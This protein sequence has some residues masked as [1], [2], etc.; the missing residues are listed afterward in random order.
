MA[1]AWGCSWMRMLV[2]WGC[3]WD[4][5]VYGMR[6]FIGWGGSWDEG[7]PGM[8]MLL[9]WG[10]SWD[11][12]VPGWYAP[13]LGMFL[14]WGGS[15]GRV[16]PWAVSGPTVVHLPGWRCLVVGLPKHTGGW[17]PP[18]PW[19]FCSLATKSSDNNRVVPGEAG[20]PLGKGAAGTRVAPRGRSG[21]GCHH[22]SRLFEGM[23]GLPLAEELS[24]H[25]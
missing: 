5:D 17:A 13:R 19:P 10:C 2:G 9:G 8:R 23:T 24:R 11:E 7:G 16:C 3:L 21:A 1:L 14:T 22:P 25:R 4:G 20:G 12:E 18:R 15:Q 6:I